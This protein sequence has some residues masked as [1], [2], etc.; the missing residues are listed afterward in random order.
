[1]RLR[2]QAGGGGG[3]GG[4]GFRSLVGGLHLCCLSDLK[5]RWA[6]GGCGLDLRVEL[7]VDLVGVA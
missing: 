3:P 6:L 1:M 5:G 7:E 4:C 2:S